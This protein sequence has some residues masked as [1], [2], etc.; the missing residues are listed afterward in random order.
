MGIVNW[1]TGQQVLGQLFYEAV[2][3]HHPFL[4]RSILDVGCGYGIAAACMCALGERMTLIDVSQSVVD[5]QRHRWRHNRQVA[6]ACS[7]IH[8]MGGSYDLIYYFLSFHH[9]ADIMAELSKI[10]SLLAQDGELVICEIS[11]NCEAPFH[12]NDIVPHDGFASGHLS[13][14]LQGN[15]FRVAQVEEL[16]ALR[17]D[18]VD[19][20]IYVIRSFVETL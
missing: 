17:K 3:A 2:K 7:T 20:G 18:G 15:G 19:Y 4:Y 6:V 12:Q 5:G 8:S 10:R 11:P 1:A 16:A 9:V 14:I 13:A